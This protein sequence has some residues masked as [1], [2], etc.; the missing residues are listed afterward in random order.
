MRNKDIKYSDKEVAIL[1][2]NL[3]I[4]QRH[5][6]QNLS[7]ARVTRLR[8]YTSA[9]IEPCFEH[10]NEGLL[11]KDE[12]CFIIT[13]AALLLFMKTK[14]ITKMPSEKI[15]RNVVEDN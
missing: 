12:A 11:T 8:E 13:S 6:I 1:L 14:K 4:A 3:V 5:V 10:I 15:A 9:L 2:N 7:T